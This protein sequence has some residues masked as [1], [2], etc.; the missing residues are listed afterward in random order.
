M[1]RF[2]LGASA[3]LALVGLALGQDEPKKKLDLVYKWD[4]LDGKTAVYDYEEKTEQQVEIKTTTKVEKTQG[5]EVADPDVT[6]TEVTSTNKSRLTMSFKK[7]ERDRG[8]VTVTTSRFQF[9]LAQP[10][11]STQTITYD[12]DKP[13][14][15]MDAKV[16][17]RIQPQIDALT[18]LLGKS[19]TLTVTRRGVVEKVDGRKETPELK[20]TFLFFPEVTKSEG[21]TWSH[22]R[23]DKAESRDG[24]LGEIVTRRTYRLAKVTEKDER[25]IEKETRT[26]LDTLKSTVEARGVSAKIV[27]SKGSGYVVVDARGLKLEE[28]TDSGY[29]LVV[30]TVSDGVER[31]IKVHSTF[32]WKLVEL[33]D[34]N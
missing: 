32:R 10:T 1:R 5:D 24:S 3:L 22:P 15:P 21:D 31:H 14:A 33:K 2:V 26:E 19:Y 25:R 9:A 12:S 7:G 27:D 29:D 16:K 13:D 6:K 11:L 4:Q 23:R 8:L 18:A 30:S 28:D 20:D 34:A 17:A